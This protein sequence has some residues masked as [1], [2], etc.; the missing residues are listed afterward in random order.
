MTWL[1]LEIRLRDE[2]KVVQKRGKSMLFRDS[3]AF[4]SLSGNCL[5]T[6]GRTSVKVRIATP[7]PRGL[8]VMVFEA[9]E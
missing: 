8:A 1:R 9:I 3:G 5:A 2:A 6:V 7:L 4:S